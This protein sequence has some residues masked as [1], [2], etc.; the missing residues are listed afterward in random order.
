MDDGEIIYTFVD[1][2]FECPW[3]SRRLA[4][5]FEAVETDD[6]GEIYEGVCQTHGTF[7]VQAVDEP[8]EDD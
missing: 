5:D 8:D 3:C 6:E 7:L 1:T 4:C 2:A